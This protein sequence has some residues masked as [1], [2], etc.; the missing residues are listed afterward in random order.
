MTNFEILEEHDGLN[1]LKTVEDTKDIALIIME[2]KLSGMHGF[3]VL[4]HLRMSGMDIPV[5][6]CTSFP[7]LKDD[8]SIMSYPK[9]IT[10]DKPASPEKLMK[11]IKKMLG[12]EE[13]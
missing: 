13:E 5:I 9:I 3:E 4:E 2:L 11:A 8:I 7:E 6:V 10:I 12:M 1:A